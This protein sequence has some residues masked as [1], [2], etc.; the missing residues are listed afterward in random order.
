[1]MVY[2]VSYFP[3]DSN[4]PNG[5][6]SV[7]SSVHSAIKSITNYCEEYDEDIIDIDYNMYNQTYYTTKGFY[8]VERF[9][10][11]DEDNEEN[12]DEP[13]DIDTDFMFNP[14]LGCFDEDC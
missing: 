9:K 14:F 10:I 13:A 2:T 11:D 1:M 5:V 3:K 6:Y 12:E 7:H 8:L 4:V